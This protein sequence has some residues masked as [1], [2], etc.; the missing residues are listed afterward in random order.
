MWIYIPVTCL[1]RCIKIDQSVIIVQVMWRKMSCDQYLIVST[2]LDYQIMFLPWHYYHYHDPFD[3]IYPFLSNCVSYFKNISYLRDA[4]YQ[5]P[6]T[7]TR[8]HFNC[9]WL[10][11]YCNLIGFVND[12]GTSAKRDNGSSVILAFCYYRRHWQFQSSCNIC[13]TM[14]N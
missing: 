14:H 9:S 5:G 10:C 1:Y 2:I 13:T 7:C 6:T 8:T 12:N 4:P 3:L 11:R